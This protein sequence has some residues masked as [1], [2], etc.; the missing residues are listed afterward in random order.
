MDYRKK[1]LMV[2]FSFLGILVNMEI[3]REPKTNH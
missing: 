2:F 3:G 1:I